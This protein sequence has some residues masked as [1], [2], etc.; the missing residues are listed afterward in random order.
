M[1]WYV[2]TV[3][4][5]AGPQLLPTRTLSAHAGAYL[6]FFIAV[7]VGGGA[8]PGKGKV[9]PCTGTKALYRPYGP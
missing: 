3:A 9:H 2:S 7:G 8:D 6:E 1:T 5:D 4:S